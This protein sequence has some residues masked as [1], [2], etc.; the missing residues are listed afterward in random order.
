LF[1][2]LENCTSKPHEISACAKLRWAG[3]STQA[4]PASIPRRSR[5]PEPAQTPIA[6]TTQ[7]NPPKASMATRPRP[8]HRPTETPAQARTRKPNPTLARAQ[9]PRTSHRATPCPSRPRSRLPGPPRAPASKHVQ[10]K[11][12]ASAQCSRSCGPNSRHADAR[13]S[14]G[15]PW[16]PGLCTRPPGPHPAHFAREGSEGRGPLGPRA[17]A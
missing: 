13:K 4:H 17:T 6:Q 7:H 9:R 11:C 3:R 14:S 1:C 10:A 16:P 15:Q 12:S 2:P 5:I 8:A